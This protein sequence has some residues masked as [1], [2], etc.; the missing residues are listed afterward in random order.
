MFC[1]ICGREIYIIYDEIEGRHY[2][3]CDCCYIRGEAD[4]LID[5]GQTKQ[6]ECYG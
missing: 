1:D 2:H 6:G 4:D 5:W 3:V